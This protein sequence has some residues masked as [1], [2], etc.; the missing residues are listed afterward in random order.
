[1][2]YEWLVLLF[3]LFGVL[4]LTQLIILRRLP[5]IKGWLG[6]RRVRLAAQKGL[7]K[8]IYLA[9]HD[10]ILPTA[11]G[12]T[13]QI[14]HIFVSRHGVFVV[15]TKN[16]SGWI[17]GNETQPLWTQTIYKTSHNFQN[18]LRQ[19][20]K[21]LKTLEEVFHIPA[22]VLHS[23]I[24]FAGDCTFKTL[25]PPQ[26]QY[27]EN[28]ITY[29]K[30]KTEVLLSD[31]QVNNFFKA[32]QLG[33][34]KPSHSNKKTHINYVQAKIKAAGQKNCPQCGSHMVL[35]T[36]KSGTQAGNQFWGCSKYPKCRGILN[37]D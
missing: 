18:P 9:L 11:A 34:Q 35:R 3:C 24:V 19:N 20:Y 29:I 32:L 14:D 6:E 36:A 27:S 13:T 8:Q 22:E 25:M 26:V 12:E 4:I 30:S 10:V 33:Q 21:H 1:M 37:V 31:E 17:F 23:V 28:Y 15:E 5:Q 2:G 16:Y 7:D